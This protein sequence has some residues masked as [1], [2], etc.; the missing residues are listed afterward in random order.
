MEERGRRNKT[1]GG[2]GGEEKGGSERRGSQRD[3]KARPLG[4]VGLTASEKR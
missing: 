1:A 4:K 3:E 2:K